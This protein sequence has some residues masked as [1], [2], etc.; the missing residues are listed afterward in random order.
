MGSEP[1]SCVTRTPES[2]PRCLWGAFLMGF[3]LRARAGPPVSAKPDPVTR[4]HPLA[5]GPHLTLVG[6]QSH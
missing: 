3:P 2:A 6:R 1:T 5:S 4:L